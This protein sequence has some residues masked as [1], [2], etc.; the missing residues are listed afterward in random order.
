MADVVVCPTGACGP[1]TLCY[2]GIPRGME[3]LNGDS[4]TCR[5]WMPAD[6]GC[7]IANQCPEC[8]TGPCGDKCPNRVDIVI[9]KG[10]C[11]M[12]E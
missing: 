3:A 6:M 5:A 12:I 1:G 11:K 9:R 4:R 7:K 2:E 8:D 10:Y